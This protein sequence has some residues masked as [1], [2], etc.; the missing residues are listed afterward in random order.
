MAGTP[1]L[2]NTYTCAFGA[3]EGQFPH[4]YIFPSPALRGV[5]LLAI[6]S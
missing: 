6:H 3:E 4:L 2:S 5:M 1:E